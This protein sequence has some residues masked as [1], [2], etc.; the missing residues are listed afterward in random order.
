[1]KVGNMKTLS[2]KLCVFLSLL[3]ASLSAQDFQEDARPSPGFGIFGNAHFNMHTADFR[4]LPGVPSCCPRY[5]DGDG[6]GFGLGLLYEFPLSSSLSLALRGSWASHSAL[7]LA[8][9][10]TTVG[11]DGAPAPAIIEHSIDAALSSV[12]FEPLLAYRL[13]GRLQLHAGGRVGYV[14]G[15][16]YDQREDLIEPGGTFE[17]G[18]RS[19]NVLSGDIPDASSMYAAVVAG[20]SYSLPMNAEGTLLLRPE[21]MYAYGLTPVVQ[22]LTWNANAAR[23]GLALVYTPRRDA[24]RTSPLPPPPPPPLPSPEPAA[25]MTIVAVDETGKEVVIDNITVEEYSST[26]SRPMLSYVFFDENSAAIPARYHRL[27]PGQAQ[28]F[29]FDDVNELTTLQAYHHV[30]NVVGRRLREHPGST[31]RITGCNA[32]I[33]EE[34]EN[35]TLSRS[36]AES[37]RDYLRTVWGIENERM[38]IAA[39]NLPAHPSGREVHDGHAENRRVELT[40]DDWNLIAPMISRDFERQAIPSRL[41]FTPVLRKAEDVQRWSLKITEKDREVKRFEG[42]DATPGMLE[43]NMSEDTKLGRDGS[44]EIDY[45][46][47]VHD[48][49]GDIRETRGSLALEQRRVDREIARYNLI[50][51]DFDQATLNPYNRR[52]VDAIRQ[53][54]DSRARVRI[55]GHTDRTG[56]A[57]YNRR[58]S[59]ER[60]RTVAR[61]LGVSHADVRG[62]GQ[63][64]DLYDNS[65][66]EGRVYSRTVEIVIDS[67]VRQ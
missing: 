20:I 28:S 33:G 51:F 60:A 12:G 59:E 31:I 21:V 40:S 17:N 27:T 55:T 37:V 8:R 43:W 42:F 41:R 54:I 66:P 15:K 62:M 7:L 25:D 45:V 24:E 64:V 36:R 32:N 2:L 49:S 29:E 35:T 3:A 47:T 39:R 23:A 11:V 22:D 48:R 46:M 14:L 5:S 50:L 56:N 67:D 30:L 4:A 34:Y 65:L 44:G 10:A 53:S 38:N 18:L 6:T 1:M 16:T 26:H 58:L 57:E 63:Q 19:R 52:I 13:F 61:T 9:E